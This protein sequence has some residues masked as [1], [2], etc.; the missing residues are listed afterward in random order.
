[1]NKVVPISPEAVAEKSGD[2]MIV[3]LRVAQLRAIVRQTVREALS[4][5]WRE[6]SHTDKAF[7]TVKQAAQASGLGAST[8]RLAV[9]RRQLR[10]QKVGRRV[11]G[12]A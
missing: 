5:G 2:E 11:L 6:T 4:H 7:L 8:V 12:Q 3:N 10:A 1:M 9:R